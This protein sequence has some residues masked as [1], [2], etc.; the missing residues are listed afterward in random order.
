MEKIFCQL[1]SFI[2]ATAVILV[3]FKQFELSKQ[4]RNIAFDEFQR[5]I[6]QQK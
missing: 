5:M 6:F 2:A 1:A 3:N 4:H